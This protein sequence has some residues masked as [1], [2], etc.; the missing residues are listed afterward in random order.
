VSRYLNDVV[1]IYMD[2]LI[3]WDSVLRMRKGA[4]V[5]VEAEKAA[6]LEVLETAAAICEEIEPEARRGWGEAAQL[7]DGEVVLPPHIQAGYDKLRE[8]GLISFGVEEEYGGF[9]L[10]S[11]I[12]NVI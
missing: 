12:S 6:L 4:D 2:E 11:F 8:A 3:D 9:G 10:P 1:R 7:V 5:D